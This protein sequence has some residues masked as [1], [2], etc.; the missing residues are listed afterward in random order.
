[1]QT[2]IANAIVKTFVNRAKIAVITAGCAKGAIEMTSAYAQIATKIK[3]ACYSIITDDRCENAVVINA[4]T[5]SA[6]VVIAAINKRLAA[7][8]DGRVDTCAISI[9][10]VIGAG[11]VVIAINGLIAT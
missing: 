3:R 7:I 8:R 5:G 11:V 1:V 10:A 9:A 2:L 6:G 4:I